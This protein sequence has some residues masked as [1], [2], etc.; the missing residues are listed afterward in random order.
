MR[1]KER[2]IEDQAK[3]TVHTGKYFPRPL[4]LIGYIVIVFGI[5]KLYESPVLG[6][7]LIIV[8]SYLSFNLAGFEIENGR[9]RN[10]F[11]LLHFKIGK[12]ETSNL[13]NIAILKRQFARKTYG[14]RTP[15]STTEKTFIYDITL[16]SETQ[17]TRVKLLRV[18]D[19]DKARVIEDQI[20]TLLDLKKID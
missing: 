8:G 10:F 15:V 4:N 13:P 16:L 12:W 6:L 5:L 19:I 3:L 14:G 1:R 9:F 18:N 2:N 17:D 11:Y 20:A 7:S